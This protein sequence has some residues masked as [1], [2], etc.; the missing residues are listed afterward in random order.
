MPRY[1]LGMKRASG[2]KPA[3][4]RKKARGGGSARR[5]QLKQ[6]E[7]CKS[8]NKDLRNEERALFVEEEIG[9]IFCSE[10]CIATFFAP[11]VARLEKEYFKQLVSSDLTDDDRQGL[12]HLRWITLQ[13]P[14]E[15]W[16]EKTLAGDQRYTLISEFQPADQPV[17][18]ICI[19]LFLRG[20][21]SFLYLAFPTRNPAMVDHYRKGERVEWVKSE[22]GESPAPA[23]SAKEPVVDGLADAWTEDETLRAQLT[24]GRKADDIP[25]EEFSLY[26]ACIE[27]TLES[28]DE[29]WTLRTGDEDSMRMYHFI[30]QYPDEN[31]S[32]WFVIVAK[33]TEDAEQI[34]LLDTFPTKDSELVDRYRRGDQ[35]IGLRDLQ[36]PSR[37][38]H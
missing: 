17:W 2:K 31:P 18:Y 10:N 30:R 33:E 1:N 22:S 23:P 16:R 20:E 7:I 36:T 9:R 4:R 5:Q 6:D 12:A 32:F 24:Q 13:E 37:L 21:P 19:C 26:Q 38:V 3:D 28:P 29:V 25:Q 8:C 34:E 15:V 27:E 35:E 11:E 14:D